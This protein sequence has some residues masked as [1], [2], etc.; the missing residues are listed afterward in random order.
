[1]TA[2]L[3]SINMQHSNMQF[4]FFPLHA[5]TR[6]IILLFVCSRRSWVGTEHKVN[7]IKMRC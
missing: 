4:E 5:I 1:M 7:K 6:K 2:S 3:S